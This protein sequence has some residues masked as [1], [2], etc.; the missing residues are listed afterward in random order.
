MTTITFISDAGIP[1]LTSKKYDLY[2]T[3]IY[4]GEYVAIIGVVRNW[5]TGEVLD[6]VVRTIA[7]DVLTVRP[8]DM[9]DYCL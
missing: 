7:G 1:E 2:K 3:A 5:E 4:A 6:I 8:I 9:T